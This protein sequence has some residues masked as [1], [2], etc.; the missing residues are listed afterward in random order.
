MVVP[1]LVSSRARRRKDAIVASLPDALDLLA[2]SVEAGM[3]F[4][5]AIAKLTEHM[6]G[7]LTDEF[8]I[9]LGEMRIGES[10]VRGA[11]QAGGA[12]RH[13]GDRARSSAR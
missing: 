9:A 1:F 3:G 6:E 10:R 8:S 13:A 4:D 11:A 5:G 7:P 2:V 12:R